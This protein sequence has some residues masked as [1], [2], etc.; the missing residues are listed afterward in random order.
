MMRVGSR[1]RNGMRRG[2]RK[3]VKKGV[4]RCWEKEGSE[5]WEGVRT[6]EKVLEDVAT[7]GWVRVPACNWQVMGSTAFD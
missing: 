2:V 1:V 5:L 6:F 3:G 4:K 7:Y